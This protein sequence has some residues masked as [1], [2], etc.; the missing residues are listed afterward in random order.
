MAIL[1]GLKKLYLFVWNVETSF[2]ISCG[3]IVRYCVTCQMRLNQGPLGLGVAILEFYWYFSR[4]SV[5]PFPS[6]LEAGVALR[7]L[8]CMHTG[9]RNIRL[10]HLFFLV[11][12]FMV[13]IWIASPL[14]QMQ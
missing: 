12:V 6:S 2:L 7:F 4:S 10:F 9:L 1:H 13:A 8:D 5:S 11:P 3:K 14:R